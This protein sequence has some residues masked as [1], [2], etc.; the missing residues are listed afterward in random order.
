MR[1]A[2]GCMSLTNVAESQIGAEG[3]DAQQTVRKLNTWA[4]MY[5]HNVSKA[6]SSSLESLRK[7]GYEEET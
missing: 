4:Q 3:S 1:T 7:R 2:F 6:Y 5:G